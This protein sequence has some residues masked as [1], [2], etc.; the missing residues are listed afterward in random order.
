[1]IL[2]ALQAVESFSA[3]LTD[4]APLA[5]SVPVL[6][7]VLRRWTAFPPELSLSVCVSLANL[8]TDGTITGEALHA[9]G[10]RVRRCGTARC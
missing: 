6:L 4:T 3:V 9:G 10:M 2:A 8:L 5:A 7:A 1:V